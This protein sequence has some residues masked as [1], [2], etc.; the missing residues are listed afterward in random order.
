[1]R[2]FSPN[3]YMH[4]RDKNNTMYILLN[5]KNSKLSPIKIER[6]FYK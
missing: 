2:C 6:I 1:M 4:R 3:T 5:T